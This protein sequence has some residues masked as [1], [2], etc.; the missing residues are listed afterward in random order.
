MNT[1]NREGGKEGA[2]CCVLAS[3][4]AFEVYLLLLH[5]IIALK[6][7]CVSAQYCNRECPPKCSMR[8]PYLNKLRSLCQEYVFTL[9]AVRISYSR[10]YDSVRDSRILFMAAG[11]Y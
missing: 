10:R 1:E 11:I 3:R 7:M 2:K 4:V 6:S 5:A 8:F 9:S